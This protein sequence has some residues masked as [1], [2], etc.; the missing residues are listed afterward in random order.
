[1]LLFP[2]EWHS[3]PLAKNYAYSRTL[4][5]NVTIHRQVLTLASWLLFTL[6]ATLCRN[7]HYTESVKVIEI[8]LMF[9]YHVCIMTTYGNLQKFL[10]LLG[11]SS[12]VT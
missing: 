8:K 12:R 11:K 3:V 1:M 7:R 6:Y 4:Y 9:K 10:T 5:K 2:F